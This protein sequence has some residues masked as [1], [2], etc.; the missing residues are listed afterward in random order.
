MP[1]V[2]DYAIPGQSLTK[3]PGSFKFEKPP[4]YT[5]ESE[6][7]AFLWERLLT[8]MSVANI[9]VLLA[10]KISVVEMAQTILFQGMAEGEWTPD[11]AFQML[12]EVVWMVEAI[13]KK[14]GVK[15]YTFKKNLPSYDK[16]IGEFADV[17]AEPTKKEEKALASVKETVF[18]GIT[19]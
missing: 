5:D 1:Q 18:T 13:A 15:D 11:L 16:F 17:L 6:A 10:N 3:A 8:P 4:H 12:Q 2:F 19:E 14:S 7:L 9:R